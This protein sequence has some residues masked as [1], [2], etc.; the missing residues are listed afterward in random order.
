M[1][2]EITNYPSKDKPWLKYY[3]YDTEKL[4]IPNMSIYQMA[5]LYN[6]DRLDNIALDIRTGK[7]NFKKGV[8]ITYREYLKKMREF[9]KS[10]SLL[11]VKENEI[12]SLVL[13][14]IIE[15]RVSI[16]GSNIL[17]ATP[18]AINPLLAPEKFN[19]IIEENNIQNIFM[20]SMFYEK[21]KNVL[22][23]RK[24]K[25]VI[26]LDGMETMPTFLKTYLRFKNNIKV[27]IGDNFIS[28]EEFIREG[29]KTKKEITPFYEEDHTAIIVGTSGTTGVPKGVCLT[30]KNL[31]AAATSHISTGLFEENDV[32]LDVLLQSIAYGVSAMHYTTCGGLKSILIPELVS[33]KMAYLLK[34]TNPDHFLGGPIHCLNIAKS[35]EFKSGE[36]KPIK[37]YV[38]GGAT[39][40]KELEKKLNKVSEDFKENGTRSDL[41]VRQGLGSTENTGGGLYQMPGSYKFGSVGI[42]LP[43]NTIGVFTPRTDIELPF[44]TMGELCITGPCVM[45][46]YLNNV[47]ETN[48]V[49]KRHSDGKVWLHM[50]DIGYIDKDGC[51]FHKHRLSD[52]FMRRGFNVHP[53]KITELLNTIS[54]IKAVGVIV[55]EHPIEEMVPI[56]CISLYN[57]FDNDK[58]KEKIENICKNN[59]DDMA[60]PYEYVYMEELPLNAG[61]KVNLP[62]LKRMYEERNSLKLKKVKDKGEKYERIFSRI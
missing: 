12:I 13:P 37:N 22:N 61:G 30:D 39:L 31:N 7:N 16:Y 8:T 36:L 45:K 52:I 5:S 62:V 41:F 28:Y 20:F 54:E 4:E 51:F 57:E 6:K 17:G 53:G 1:K 29:K 34:T 40:K 48:K 58:V 23:I 33:D 18:Y 32:F 2:E 10:L 43:L 3:D 56:A 47:E 11:G 25:N 14:N 26:F 27:P 35:E 49:L 15:S 44:N 46:E 9:A 50:G 60:I 59:L 55:V 42:P 19:T 24:Y 38:S 21:Y